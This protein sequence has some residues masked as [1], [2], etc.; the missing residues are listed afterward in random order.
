[1]PVRRL[2]PPS[3]EDGRVEGCEP[4]EEVE[5][6][7]GTEGREGLG[8]RSRICYS[9]RAVGADS[10]GFTVA[11]LEPM[12]QDALPRQGWKARSGYATAYSALYYILFG[13]EDTTLGLHYPKRQILFYKSMSP[14]V[15][16]CAA[17]PMSTFPSHH[18]FR[19]LPPCSS[20]CHSCHSSLPFL[21]AFKDPNG[22]S[23]AVDH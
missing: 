17:A 2:S 20:S 12:C 4:G 10:G 23:D 3:E 9:S 11:T 5:L 18:V 8:R 14:C 1:M 15:E 19:P 6:I 21:N 16:V 22:S 13:V 7:G